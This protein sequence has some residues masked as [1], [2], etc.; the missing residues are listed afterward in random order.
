V[1]TGLDLATPP[2]GDTRPWP[3]RLDPVFGQHVVLA[4]VVALLALVAAG[5][6][7]AVTRTVREPRPGFP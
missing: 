7:I 4:M 5:F 1:K 3:A 2:A 6:G